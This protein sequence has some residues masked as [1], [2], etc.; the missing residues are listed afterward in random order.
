[1]VAGGPRLRALERLRASHSLSV[2]G[3]CLSIG[4]AAPLDMAHLARLREL[5]RRHEPELVS[6]HL[7]WSSHGSVFYN[8][9]LPLPYTRST[10]DHVCG[11]LHQ[12][13]DAL[14][15]RILLEN[16]ATYVTFASSTF[17][18]T[19]FLR[20]VV[21]RTGCGLLL[22]I[23][24]VVVSTTNQ[25]CDA[26][27]YLADFPFHAVGEIH[28]AGHSRQTDEA[29]K[30]FLIDSHDGTV[31]A[32]VWNLYQA[33]VQA[34]GVRPTLIEWDSRIPDWNALREQRSIAQQILDEVRMSQ[35]ANRHAA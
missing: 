15:R 35:A 32:N 31:D 1:M 8:D 9:L 33:V 34:H 2:H 16:P 27:A 29:G 7:A 13:Q 14:A 10:L 23:N 26:Q 30:P 20:A 17:R 21:Q 18:E 12:V 24:N 22:D 28:L 3:V 6:E 4:G 11:H 5:V 19:E 25:G